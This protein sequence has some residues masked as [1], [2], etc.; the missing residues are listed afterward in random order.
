METRIE[1]RITWEYGINSGQS[2]G[3]TS[4]E[5]LQNAIETETMG[6]VTVTK[7]EQRAVTYSDWEVAQ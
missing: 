4:F 2:A 1:R 3:F 7:R 6:Y 5:N